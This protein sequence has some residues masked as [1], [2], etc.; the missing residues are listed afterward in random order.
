MQLASFQK[1][2]KTIGIFFV[3]AIAL[4]VTIYGGN[5]AAQ[6]F[7]KASTCPAQK[8]ATAQVTANS[9]VVSWETLEI[10]QG[11]V[12]YGTDASALSFTAPESTSGKIHN[13][14]LTL[15]TPNT[16]YYYIIVIGNTSCDSGGQTCTTGTCVPWSFTTNTITPSVAPTK[17]PTV[18]PTVVPT[19]AVSSPSSTTSTSSAVVP[20]SALSS[21]CQQ[22]KGNIGANS[23]SSNWSTIQQYDVDSNDVINGTDVI[24]CQKSGK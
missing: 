11:R 23:S 1:I 8:V 13:V 15:L 12:E 20:T 22:V 5:Q 21:F 16:V 2:F 19:Q 17:E 7:A 18:I 14:P 4:G 24:K 10:T 9:A 3:L 6:R